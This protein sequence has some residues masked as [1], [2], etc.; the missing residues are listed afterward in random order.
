MIG[1]LVGLSLNPDARPS[2][3][4]YESLEDNRGFPW[5]AVCA[6]VIQCIVQL[7]ER[8]AVHAYV[9]RPGVIAFQCL[10]REGLRSP[11]RATMDSLALASYDWRDFS[12]SCGLRCR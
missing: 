4:T 6:S 3:T 9:Y 7:L 12:T 11:C 1:G 2:D 8:T 5:S 10:L